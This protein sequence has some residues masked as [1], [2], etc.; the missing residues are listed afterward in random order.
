MIILFIHEIIVG[1]VSLTVPIWV[2]RKE[3][4]LMVKMD[5]TEHLETHLPET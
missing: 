2:K 5:S 3:V 1:I 4:E